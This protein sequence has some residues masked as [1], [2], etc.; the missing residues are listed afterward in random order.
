MNAPFLER[1]FAMVRRT[2]A[3]PNEDDD[4]RIRRMIFV[5]ASLGGVVSLVGR[6]GQYR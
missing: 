1:L 6:R 4:L 3:N 2:G 5:G